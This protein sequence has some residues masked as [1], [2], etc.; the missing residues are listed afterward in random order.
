M[1]LDELIWFANRAN[2]RRKGEARA[3]KA[4]HERK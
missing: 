1:A 2:E 3:I 4:A